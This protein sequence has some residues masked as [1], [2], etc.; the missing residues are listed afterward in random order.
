V[1]VGTAPPRAVI[2]GCSGPRLAA[3]ERRFFAAADPLGFILFRRNC[4]DPGQTREL[5]SSLRAAVGRADAPVLIDQEG[6]RVQRLMPPHWRRAPAPAA[7]RGIARRD[8]SRAREAARLNARLM[9]EEMFRLGVSVDCAP[10]LDVPAAGAHPVIGDR[11]AGD[12]PELAAL[13]GGAACEGLLDGGVLPAIK[14]V[15]GHGRASMDSHAAL[16]LVAAPRAELERVDFAPFR[17][18]AGMPWAMTAHVLYADLDPAAPA[19][20]S[21]RVIR[22]VVRGSIGFSG[23]LVTDDISMGALAGP[24]EERA[25]AALAAGCDAVIHCNGDAAEMEALAAACGPLGAESLARFRRGESMRRAPKPFD[26]E[27]ALGRLAELMAE[28]AA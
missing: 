8:P 28:A 22:D 16:P 7:F 27:A 21:P 4:V 15:P 2:F 26:R 25:R 24:L 3:S 18:L 11:A 9:A 23:F 5:V 20:L 1:T 6:G 10:V 13:L 12:T 14:H 17:A 19:T